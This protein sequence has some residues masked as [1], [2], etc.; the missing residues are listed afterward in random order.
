MNNEKETDIVKNKSIKTK[1]VRST[2]LM[3][4]IPLIILGGASIYLIYQSTY[5]S[6]E[7]TMSELASIA[8]ERVEEELIANCNLAR[9]LGCVARLTSDSYTIEQ[10]LEIVDQK[11][12]DYKLVSGEL[13]GTDGKTYRGNVDCSD[14]EYFKKAMNGELCITEPLENRISGKM[15]VMISAP[16]WK[17]GLPNSTIM[18]VVVLVAPDTILNDIVLSIQ[19]SKHGAAY[20]ID[21]EGATVAHYNNDFVLNRN[22]TIENAKTD[23]K[24]TGI[25]KL[26][27]KMINGEAG[28][29]TYRYKGVNKF[30][31]YAP[32]KSTDGWS[33]GINAPVSDFMGQ[34]IV[35]IVVICSLIVIAVLISLFSASKIAEAIGNPIIQ[36]ASRLNLLAQGDLQ[37]EVPEIAIKNELGTLAGATQ[38]IVSGMNTMI[39]DIRYLLGKMAEGDFNITTTAEESY[40]G[41]FHEILL[42]IRKINRSLSSTLSQINESANQVSQGSEQL[43]DGAQSLAEGATDQAGA[44]EELFAMVGNV[45]EQV[46]DNAKTS[47]STSQEVIDISN[48]A[49]ESTEKI[50][51]MTDAMSKIS[52]NSNQIKNI[53]KSIED[54]AAQTNLLSL[55]AAIEAARAGDAGRGFAVVADE[56]RELANQSAKSVVDT[57]ELIEAALREVENGNQTVDRTAEFL[58]HI[59]ESL[60]KV[61]T[62][63]QNVSNSSTQQADSMEQVRL[64]VEQI[65]N[66]VEENSAMAEESSATSEELSAQ[67]C[68]LNDLVG[69]FNLRKI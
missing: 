26:E 45:T 1:I 12:A 64:A 4:A 25:A 3:V 28:F 62:S 44:V 32:I 16:V 17:N 38:A 15:N 40:I 9:E 57:R 59:I 22:S 68:A 60:G 30:L 48:K 58:T 6:I 27:K 52:D 34:T 41:D 47:F 42:S 5:L 65:A 63:I 53:I 31:A 33:I 11:V 35:A 21:N 54:I 13:I 29:D 66:V 36:C 43:A 14:R 55:N 67:A 18:G 49:K 56:I 8:S 39:G 10:K 19:V 69:Q 50:R 51:E 2:L 37:S 23:K 24:L 46:N 7:Q 61:E 20:M